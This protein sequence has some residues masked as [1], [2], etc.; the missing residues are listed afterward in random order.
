MLTQLRTHGSSG[1]HLSGG[2]R[3]MLSGFQEAAQAVAGRDEYALVPFWRFYDTL[4]T[5]LEGYIRR[6]IDRCAEQAAEGNQGLMPEDVEVL[7]LL[8][9]VRY[10]GDL[11][12][13]L[14]N[15]TIMMADR[16]DV[17][18]QSLRERVKG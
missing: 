2:E 4:S 16:M 12:A 1:K 7:K 18:V 6:V 11:K 14:T 15:V 10:V 3:S 8:F 17:D 9:L 13:N 5:F